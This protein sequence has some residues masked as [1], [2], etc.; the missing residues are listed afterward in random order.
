[1]RCDEYQRFDATGLAELVRRGEISREELLEAALNAI[2]RRNKALHAVVRLRAE[3]ARLES[4]QMADDAFFAGVPTLAKDLLM[5]LSGEPLTSGSAALMS[6]CALEDAP[7]ITRSR[8]AGLVIVGQ[9]VTPEL[10]LMGITEPRAFPHPVNPWRE[11]YSPGGSSGGA[12]VAVASGMVPLALAGD[13]GGSIRIPASYCGLFGFKPSRGRV[14]LAPGVGEV[15]Q[16]AVIE[17][18]ITR[19]VRDSAALLE[20]INGMTPAGPYPV[21]RETGYLAALAS[22]AKPQRIALS[23]G[24]PLGRSLGTRV[25]AEVRA[26]VEKTAAYLADMGHEVEWCD[27]PVN[28]EALVESYLTL[29]LG[30]LAADL[31]WISRQT[32]TPVHRLAIEPSTRAIGR[33]G[34]RLSARAYELA[35]REW[36]VAAGQMSDFHQRYDALVMP[37]TAD[38]APRLGELYPSGARE[39]LMGL[40]AIPGAAW[41][42]LK[43]GLLKRMAADALSRTPFTQLANFTGQPAMSVPMHI[44]ANGLPIGVQIVGRLGEDKQLMQLAFALEQQENW[45]MHLPRQAFRVR[46][47]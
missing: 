36:F 40:L 7:L 10:G 42:A 28:G 26:A 12:A 14:P 8:A 30:H 27:P 11:G 20:Q 33:L 41:L 29:Y 46:E 2:E 9:S 35:K 34:A 16:G 23:L 31:E 25:S 43:G 3:K 47:G 15:W 17:H 45:Q 32:H 4:R 13:G 37:V 19:S 38:T 21:L 18:A 6:W 44:G 1:M 22:P 39:K 5:G 24:E